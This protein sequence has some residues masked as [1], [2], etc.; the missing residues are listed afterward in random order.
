MAALNKLM[1][2]GI[3]AD[4]DGRRGGEGEGQA[5]AVPDRPLR[6]GQFRART[7]GVYG[8]REGFEV[9]RAVVAAPVDEERRRAG[10]A[11]QVRALYVLGDAVRAHVLLQVLG[12]ASD[13]QPEPLGVRDQIGRPQCVL[14]L[15]Q[16]VVHLPECALIGGGLGGLGGEL[17]V[18]VH[19]GERQMTPYVA[20]VPEVAQQLAHGRSEERR[21]GKECRSRWSPY[22]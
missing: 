10:H 21:V 14:V 9:I 22:H 1:A 16:Q 6:R 15:E 5:V 8:A 3:E 13:V 18:R 11:A 17:G 19:V 2:R 12:E 7:G 4:H 20:D